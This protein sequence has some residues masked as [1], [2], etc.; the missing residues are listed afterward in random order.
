MAL[1]RAVVIV[2]PTASGKT[3]I[4]LTLASRY[5]GE[6]ISADSRQVYRGMDIGTGKE[7]ESSVCI[8]GESA[9]ITRG[10][11]QYCVDCVDPDASYTLADFQ[12]DAIRSMQKIW[13]RGKTPFIVGG[14]GLYVQAL[15][16]HLDIPNVPP[17]AAF[18]AEVECVIHDRGLD[19]VYL[20]LLKLDP[21]AADF[22]QPE[23]K[24]RIIRALEVATVTGK[25]FS[26]MQKRKRRFFIAKQ[27]GAD[28]P[29][30][31]L[32]ARI[33]RRIDA[34]F[35]RGFSEEVRA[36]VQRFSPALPALSGI[37]YAEVAR[38]L[39]GDITMDAARTI[40]K[41][42]T[43]AYARRQLSW[44]RRDVRIQWVKKL[45]EADAIVAPF[46]S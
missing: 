22:V 35:T 17:N 45:E 14:T 21:D 13:A 26:K 5:H 34:M 37:G 28:W 44:F 9:T 2:G 16:D 40:M 3:D 43:H 46:L 7:K 18:R 15:V 20:E 12:G 29:R 6:I 38:A 25:P 8:G 31:E 30:E 1:P 10:I 24:R 4:G 39:S 36:L 19:Q 33:D 41:K 23:N 42:R 11:P 27:I 32:Y